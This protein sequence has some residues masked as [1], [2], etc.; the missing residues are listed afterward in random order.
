MEP[1]VEK[2]RRHPRRDSTGDEHAVRRRCRRRSHCVT[3]YGTLPA[4]AGSQADVE[5][6]CVAFA[7]TAFLE[8]SLLTG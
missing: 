5:A 8:S 2:P 7:S 4:Q 1:K 6:P 3:N